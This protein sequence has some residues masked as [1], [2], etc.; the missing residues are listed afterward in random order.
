MTQ[1][2]NSYRQDVFLDDLRQQQDRQQQRIWLEHQEMQLSFLKRRGLSSASTVLDLG[3]GPMRLGS[4]VIPLLKDGWYYGQDINPST[5]AFGEQVLR[6]SGISEQ[7]PY[8]LFA[9]DQFDLSLVDRPVQIAFSNSLFSHLTLNSI[10]TALLQLQTVLAP[11]G[12][13]YATFFS[14]DSGCSGSTPI[15][16]ISGGV[17]SIHT[18]IKIHITT[19]FLFCRLYLV[20]Q[21]SRLDLISDF[22]PHPDHGTISA[23]KALSLVQL[24]AYWFAINCPGRNRCHSTFTSC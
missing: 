4:A 22:A 12:V 17:G 23:A 13:F 3:C 15:R 2:E 20:R 16:A 9:S 19:R 14:L 6:D 24:N 10:F 1:S 11:S 7:A 18:L 21:V 8:T 5:I